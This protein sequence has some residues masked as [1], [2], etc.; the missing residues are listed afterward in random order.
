M[1]PTSCQTA[2]PRTRQTISI[3]FRSGSA[4]RI[5]FKSLCQQPISPRPCSCYLST[6]PR[7][8][9]GQ[10]TDARPFEQAIAICSPTVAHLRP[11]ISFAALWQAVGLFVDE[12]Q[13]V[14]GLSLQMAAGSKLQLHSRQLNRA[15]FAEADYSLSARMNAAGV[16]MGMPSK[17]RRSS[18]SLSP[19][20]MAS[21][22]PVTAS[23]RNLS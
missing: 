14:A 15:D 18:R 21:A 11:I 9:R 23:A 2:P 6:G 17:T 8:Y 16:M 5:F 19:E 13:Y 1:S 3:G 7:L 20:M 10:F 12:H 4:Q 22:P